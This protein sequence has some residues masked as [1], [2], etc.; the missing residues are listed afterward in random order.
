MNTDILLT[1]DEAIYSFTDL[2][3]TYYENQDP[4]GV[5]PIEGQPDS[6]Y[7]TGEFYFKDSAGNPVLSIDSIVLQVK[8]RLNQDVS[9]M[10]AMEQVTLIGPTLDWWRIK[11]TNNQIYFGTNVAD[12]GSFVFTFTVTHTVP[13]ST[14]YT[15]VLTTDPEELR[16]SNAVPVVVIPAVDII[17]N[18]ILPTNPLTGTMIDVS[19]RNGNS[20]TYYPSF[21]ANLYY[22]LD[23]LTPSENYIGK[24]SVNS[25]NGD[26]SLLDTY[27]KQGT[28]DIRIKI[29]DATSSSGL[30]TPGSLSSN[31][32]IRVIAPSMTGCASWDAATTIASPSP[33]AIT[34][35]YRCYVAGI[36]NV[37]KYLRPGETIASGMLR[38]DAYH[39]LTAG[40]PFAFVPVNGPFN[41]VNFAS[42]IND[43]TKPIGYGE[44]GCFLFNNETS[45]AL[46]Y[47]GSPP[48]VLR[49][50]GQIIT[51]TS[52][53]III[54]TFPGTNFLSN[55]TPP[56]TGD[57]SNLP[58][59]TTS[60]SCSITGYV[61]TTCRH[62]KI[63]NNSPFPIAWTALHG[64]GRSIIG[65]T[66]N[67]FATVGSSFYGGTQPLV[68]FATLQTNRTTG[69]SPVVGGQI[70][71]AFSS[72]TC[73]V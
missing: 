68:R 14:T 10:F 25:S 22:T 45:P 40:D 59:E 7:I 37:W 18:Y 49:F 2:D 43:P 17:P 34:T 42:F 58:W 71:Y 50:T 21:L 6:K 13:P 63:Y 30:A 16:I 29:Q 8:N 73:P 70:T 52:R 55:Y 51:N 48:D 4:L 36:V 27:I 57:L 67:S 53:S 11:I 15:R 41:E 44:F 72:T 69:I 24:F 1:G 64:N 38:L 66:I 61:P 47:G 9:S 26:I 32:T 12:Y 33:P 46:P 31:R 5:N 65:G 28:Y 62:W 60:S 23:P 19:G 39:P 56:A 35:T 3:F 54:D 20:S